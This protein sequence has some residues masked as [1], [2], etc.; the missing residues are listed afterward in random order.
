MQKKVKIYFSNSKKPTFNRITQA[1]AEF[2]QTRLKNKDIDIKKWWILSYFDNK[3][4]STTYVAIGQEIDNDTLQELWAKGIKTTESMHTGHDISVSLIFDNS[5][6]KQQKLFIEKWALLALQKD[7]VLSQKPNTH[8]TTIKNISN[9]NLI[10]IVDAINIA[11]ELTFKPA[12]IITP[13]TMTNYVQDLFAK[14][15]NISVK[16]L[17]HKDLQKEN[18]N[19]FLAVGQW[20][21]QK[22]KMVIM[23]YTPT[24]SKDRISSVPNTDP[25]VLIGKWLTYDSG[26]LYAKPYPYMNDMFGDMGW[27]ATVVWI[28]SALQDLKINKKIVAIIWLAE[29]MP[30]GN[31]YKNWDIIKSKNWK[32]VYVWHTDAEWRLVLADMLAYAKDNYKASLTLDFA[33]LTWAVMAALWEMY[34]WIF[35]DNNKLLSKLYKT[36]QQTNDLTR[37]LPLDKDIKNAVKHKLADLSNTGNLKWILWASTAAA[38]LSNFV[39]DT[40]KWIHCDIAWPALRGQMRKAYDLPHGMWTWAM[41]HTILEYLK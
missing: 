29:N 17:D 34:T 30:D 2:F 13:D 6:K 22:P 3:I 12:N 4:N 31:A 38:F 10:H 35:S 20:S 21:T 5:I 7:D 1:S 33:T 26:W 8:K 19:L 39:D 9:K 40:Q 14:N 15:K 23:E 25:I 24:P 27:A 37:A 18:M 32:T 16:T 11:R 28:M 36:A 41:V